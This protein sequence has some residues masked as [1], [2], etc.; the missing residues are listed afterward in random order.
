MNRR[1]ILWVVAAVVGVNLVIVLVNVVAP[2][3]GGHRS[4]SLATAPGG[5][6]GWAE[7][8]GRNGVR[9]VA[10][11]ADLGTARLPPG[12]TV[13]ALDVPGLSRSDARVLRAH[14]AAGGRVVAGGARPQDWLGVL[15]PGLRWVDTGPRAPRVGDTRLRTAGSG[16]WR[17]GSDPLLV[18]RRVGAGRLE[19]LADS[20]PLQNARLAQADD[21]A[22]AL[23]LSGRGPLI[24]AEAAHGYGQA[25]GV[26]ALPATARW[27]LG[28][29]LVAALALMLARGRRFGPPEARE[30]DLAPPRAAYVDALAAALA[31]T[32]DP[33]GAMAPV[34]E[35]LAAAGVVAPAPRDD[36]DAVTLARRHS[37]LARKGRT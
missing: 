36:A 1:A 24:F 33:A 18:Q 23:T 25:R 35:A 2:G 7:L 30:R 14:A 4:S 9:V 10:L 5:F 15:A 3:P 31:K 17:G 26:A 22:F 12:A 32:Q 34:R 16:S 29:L 28:L 20:S 11:R 8:A 6:A 19:L 37:A 27:A 21:A 13:V